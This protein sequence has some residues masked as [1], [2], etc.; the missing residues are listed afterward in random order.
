MLGYSVYSD[1]EAERHLRGQIAAIESERSQLLAEKGKIEASSAAER[2]RLSEQLAF[3][4]NELKQ[5]FEQHEKVQ[6]ELA[7]AQAQLKAIR[8]GKS[9]VA[10]IDVTPRPAP[11]DVMAAQK[12]LTELGYGKLEADGVVGPSTK[13]AIEE[14]QRAMGLTVTGELHAQTLQ[15]LLGGG[16]QMA[17]Q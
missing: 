13:Q 4:R 12:A 10:F 9:P 5:L 3:A 2:K 1:M 14:Y 6:A 17:S 7:E 11:Q 16:N 15:V 8:P